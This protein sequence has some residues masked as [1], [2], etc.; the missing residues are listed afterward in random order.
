MK[1]MLN[2][3][4]TKLEMH[5]AALLHYVMN[6]DPELT[7]E[8]VWPEIDISWYEHIL[9]IIRG[10]T[11]RKSPQIKQEII[12]IKKETKPLLSTL[13][14]QIIEKLHRQL[15]YGI[16]AVPIEMLHKWIKNVDNHDLKEALEEIKELGLTDRDGLGKNP[17][18]LKSSKRSEIEKI[19][20][21]YA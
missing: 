4:A 1:M 5:P 16:A 18:S 13:A 19:I 2:E 17:V 8:E 10:K 11:E 7:F 15:K 12:P 9:S 21:E 14:Y 20:Q 6:L 3:A